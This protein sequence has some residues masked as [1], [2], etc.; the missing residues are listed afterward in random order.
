MTI[1]LQRQHQNQKQPADG[2]VGIHSEM[3]KSV[4]LVS[5][6]SAKP[7]QTFPK[8]LVNISLVPNRMSYAYS[9]MVSSVEA[10]ESHAFH[11]MLLS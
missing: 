9:S 5:F 4:L 6:T 3:K 2:L 10:V 7:V 1:P 11:T 8:R